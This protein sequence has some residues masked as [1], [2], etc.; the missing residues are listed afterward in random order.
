MNKT[1]PRLICAALI[2]F[3]AFGATSLI[4]RT[5]LTVGVLLGV[6]S[7]ILMIISRTQLGNSFAVKPEA[8]NLITTGLYSRIQ[9]PMYL[10]L[11]V[12]I[13]ALIIVLAWP[14]ALLGWGLLVVV[15]MLQA[16]REETVLAAAFGAE[17][18]SYRRQTWL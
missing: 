8:R 11:D 9:H 16:Q 7:F 10:F 15:Q 18:D 13:L 1:V 2:G 4:E 3:M 5:R 6:P 14:I 17:Y 12:F